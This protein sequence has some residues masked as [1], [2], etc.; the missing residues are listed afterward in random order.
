MISRRF[1]IAALPASV[2]LPMEAKAGD[3]PD[4]AADLVARM[5]DEIGRAI[6]SGR[7]ALSMAPVFEQ[8]LRRYGDVPVIARSALGPAARTAS[9]SQMAAYTSAFSGYMAR[10]Y[11]RR[12]RDFQGGRFE[13]SKVIPIRNFYEVRTLAVMPDRPAFEVTF[14]ASDRSGQMRVF[15]ILIEGVSVLGTEQVEIRAMLDRRRG[16]IDAMTADLRGAG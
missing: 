10:K 2:F 1:L 8:I 6:N 9:P 14:L 3:G 12:F 16:D 13:I 7:D 11:G 5:S 15:N 4:A